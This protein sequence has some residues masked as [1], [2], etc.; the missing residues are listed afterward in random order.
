MSVKKKKKKSYYEFRWWDDW[1][2][3]LGD[4]VILWILGYEVSYEMI[5]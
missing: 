2:N 3:Q 1:R 4:K 5:W